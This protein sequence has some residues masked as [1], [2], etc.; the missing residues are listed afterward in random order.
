MSSWI[1]SIASVSLLMTALDLLMTEGETK[2]YIKGIMSIIVIF[3]VIAPLPKLFNKN[4]DTDSILNTDEKN[5]SADEGYLYRVYIARYAEK[6]LLVQKALAEKG[7][8]H[9]VVKIN[10][11]YGGGMEVEIVNVTV[12]L[13][14]AVITENQKNININELITG[15]VKAALG[16]EQEKVII[17]G[18]IKE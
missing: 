4:F 5:V 1:I 7:L 18:E 9:A 13:N 14:T 15:T 17:Y 2:K 8:S 3:V 16:V 6:E 10:I 11:A 12:D